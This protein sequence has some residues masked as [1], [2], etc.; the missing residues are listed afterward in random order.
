MIAGCKFSTDKE[1]TSE[2]SQP[3]T[4]VH[5]LQGLEEAG[6]VPWME[7]PRMLLLG[8][9]LEKHSKARPTQKRYYTTRVVRH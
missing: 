4:K 2:F 5:D 1:L 6:L 7:V 3:S 8:F 9:N